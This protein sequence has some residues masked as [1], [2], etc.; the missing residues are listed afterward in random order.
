MKPT[1][2]TL[3]LT[4]IFAPSHCNPLIAGTLLLLLEDVRFG[5]LLEWA[6]TDHEQSQLLPDYCTMF[7]HPC[8][9]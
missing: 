5:D 9:R 4:I 7:A 1:W 3:P 6:Y 2:V 8:I